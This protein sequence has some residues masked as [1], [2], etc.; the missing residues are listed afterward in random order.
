MKSRPRKDEI[1]TSRSSRPKANGIK[2]AE[3]CMLF[4]KYSLEKKYKKKAIYK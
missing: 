3:K 1:F 2:G 4:F